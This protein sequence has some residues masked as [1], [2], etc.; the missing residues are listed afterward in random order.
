MV[1]I[2]T[3]FPTLAASVSEA[4]R[5]SPLQ[6]RQS[7][8][9]TPEPDAEEEK[10]EVS[11]AQCEV[12]LTGP[13]GRVQHLASH[14]DGRSSPGRDACPGWRRDAFD[15]AEADDEE[16]KLLRQSQER[17]IQELG[18]SDSRTL[19]C[20]KVTLLPAQSRIVSVA[21]K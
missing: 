9:R 15:S 3:A 7:T 18:F 17:L 5:M 20:R 1:N 12:T 6:I 4:R 2:D 14:K 8:P 13:D 10:D 21:S 19:S 11:P 16:I